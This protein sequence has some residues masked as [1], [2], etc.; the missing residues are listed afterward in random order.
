MQALTNHKAVI[1]ASEWAST[2]RLH[3]AGNR[4]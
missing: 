4:H 3:L 2:L 1:V